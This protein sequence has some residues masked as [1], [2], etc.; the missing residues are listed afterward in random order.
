MNI[1]QFVEADHFAAQ[2]GGLAQMLSVR[3]NQKLLNQI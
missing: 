1:Y 3:N 2:N